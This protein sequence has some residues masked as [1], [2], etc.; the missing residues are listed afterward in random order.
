MTLLK[1]K[2]PLPMTDRTVQKLFSGWH[3]PLQNL[4]FQE[5]PYCCGVQVMCGLKYWGKDGRSCEHVRVDVNDALFSANIH[6]ID[7]KLS[8]KM[9]DKREEM[10]EYDAEMFSGNAG[11]PYIICVVT[12]HMIESGIADVLVDYFGFGAL[13]ADFPNLGTQDVSNRLRIMGLSLNDYCD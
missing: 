1:K 8:Q 2:P 9:V 13:D 10:D 7:A 11:R 5:F 6:A 3:E 4:H 12:E